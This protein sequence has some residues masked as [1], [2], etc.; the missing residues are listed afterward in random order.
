MRS[1]KDTIEDMYKTF[2]AFHGSQVVSGVAESNPALA[3]QL[4]ETSNRMN[5]LAKN[6][7]DE[8]VE[9]EERR[10]NP[11][12]PVEEM[13]AVQ[14]RTRRKT[15]RSQFDLATPLGY[16]AISDE[17]TGETDNENVQNAFVTENDKD[18]WPLNDWTSPETAQHYHAGATP[19]TGGGSSEAL[20]QPLFPAEEAYTA[21]HRR[22]NDVV[23]YAL[24]VPDSNITQD[25]LPT[26]DSASKWSRQSETL[27][28]PGK[29]M[30][31]MTSLP[32]PDSYAYQEVSFARRLL[33]SSLESAYSLM[34][35]PNTRPRDIERLCKLS[36]CFTN[37]GRIQGYL[38]SLIE[39][40]GSQ[41]LEYWGAPAWHVGSAGLHYPR[42]G[43]DAAGAAPE[44]WAGK[45]PVGPLHLDQP[46][47]PMPGCSKV[48]EVEEK[49]GYD[50]E[51][52]DPNDV[53]Q[54]L[55]SKGIRLDGQ[56]TIVELDE[57]ETIPAWTDPP[58]QSKDSPA[59][60]TPDDSPGDPCSPENIDI[61]WSDDTFLQ[62][63]DTLGYGENPYISGMPEIDMDMQFHDSE[64]SSAKRFSTG[65][66]LNVFANAMPAFRTKIKKFVDIDKFV[67]STSRNILD[68]GDE[69]LMKC[70][71]RQVWRL[72]GPCTRISKSSRRC[73]A[74]D[75]NNRTLLTDVAIVRPKV[76]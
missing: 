34:T 37:S 9:D 5:N 39:R 63:I 20:L 36:R 16:R 46:D 1:L 7:T 52:F 48:E 10:R 62:G 23:Q 21:S 64:Q 22:D 31:D 40:S 17:D 19:T 26:I 55:R 35:N 4:Q 6:S 38:K 72:S 42:V 76:Q 41:N 2:Q 27:L 33:R 61:N 29:G 60:S 56:S 13:E 44:W 18:I 45:G 43:I 8:D 49:V 68:L 73:S 28:P 65:L 54:Y 66:D 32:S 69:K 74:V 51:W 25:L 71:N 12:V 11:A 50:G 58:I 14:L 24:Q 67:N 59:A 75:C 53:E 30:F 57:E 15:E 70:S 47:T 3:E